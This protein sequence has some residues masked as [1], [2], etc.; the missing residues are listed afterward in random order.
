[1]RLSR[2][3]ERSAKR[4]RVRGG[5]EKG[6]AGRARRAA[7]GD[8][9]GQA[10][11][12]RRAYPRGAGGRT[13]RRGGRIARSNRRLESRAQ[14]ASPN[15]SPNPKPESQARIPS[16]NPKPE[17]QARMEPIRRARPP[18]SAGGAV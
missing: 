15:P 6:N 12:A 5:A 9:S 17:S 3:S 7:G 4:K 13:A 16:P 14:I 18:R 11:E 8:V 1:M 2:G 10:G